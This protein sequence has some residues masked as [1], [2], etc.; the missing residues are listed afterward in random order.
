MVGAL[1]HPHLHYM[2][3]HA[4]EAVCA[5][6]HSSDAARATFES[7]SALPGSNLPDGNICYGQ[8]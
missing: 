8:P 7:V 3:R 1:G 4:G 5:Y 6:A 2:V